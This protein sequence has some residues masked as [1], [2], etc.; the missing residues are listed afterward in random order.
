M[1]TALNQTPVSIKA[2]GHIANH[3][4]T[5]NKTVK[6]LIPAA[7]II[8]GIA[9]FI[10]GAAGIQAGVSLFRAELNIAKGVINS[11]NVLERACDWGI[12]ASRKSL[13]KRWEK[14]ASRIS[15]FAAQ[16]LETVLFIDKCTSSFFYQA[17]L[18]LGNLP[19]F[20]LVKGSLYA[21]SAAFGL[22]TAG[23]DLSTANST[24]EKAEL[25]LKKWSDETVEKPDYSEKKAEYNK[26]DIQGSIH[27]KKQLILACNVFSDQKS[28]KKLEKELIGLNSELAAVEKYER[29][30]E[31]LKADDGL[32]KVKTHKSN[33]YEVR[34][35][36]ADKIIEKS[37][38]AIAVQVGKI[39]MISVGM[40]VVGISTFYPALSGPVA[41]LV[42][43]S[44][45]LVAASLGLSRN[46]Y[47][48]VGPKLEKEPVFEL[49]TEDA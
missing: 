49:S 48:A 6:V 16:I 45:G 2:M 20:E 27:A 11:T 43:S 29:Y 47:S 37:W 12:E 5:L 32:E 38:L 24:K 21:V 7:D 26:Q 22:W 28:K 3:T 30:E 31:A 10:P 1:T 17:S 36:N 9:G 44:C 40:T 41:K 33:K 14:A 42:M 19:I 34:I 46:I 13:L 18:S 8:S 25:K 4:D 35:A 23:Q 15:L 39:F